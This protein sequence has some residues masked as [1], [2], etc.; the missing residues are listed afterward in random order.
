MDV[1][2]DKSPLRLDLAV[3]PALLVL[4][5]FAGIVEVAKSPDPRMVI[6]AWT[7]LACIA[8]TAIFYLV[9]YGGGLPQDERGGYAN[10]VVKAGVIAAMFWGIAGMTVGLVAALQLVVSQPLLFPGLRLRPISAASARCT[11]PR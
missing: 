8:T 2:A 5:L 9:T 6:Q 3:I 10:N 1:A 11:P 4:A 7:F